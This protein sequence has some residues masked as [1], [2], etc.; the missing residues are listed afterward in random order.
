V[1]EAVVSGLASDEEKLKALHDWAA[2]RVAYD[3]AFLEGHYVPQ[4]AE[5][6]FARRTAVCAGYAQLY[7]SLARAVGLEAR[8]VVGQAKGAGGEVDG[9]GHAWNVVRAGGRER[10]VD[11]T[12][13]S[14]VLE[15]TPQGRVF[16]KR[17]RTDYLFAPPEV[18]GVDHFPNEPRD[19]LREAPLSRGDFMRQPQMAPE[20]F[21]RGLEL[22]A[23]TRS[24]V[25]VRGGVD[26][27]VDTSR[28][29]GATFLLA[30]RSPKGGGASVPCRVQEGPVSTVRCDFD[31]GGD[32]RV[33]LFASS[34]RYGVYDFVGEIEALDTR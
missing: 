4:D 27:V 5:A 25:S 19:Q 20:F 10:L 8:Y 34:K 13:D 9:A 30:S 29:R 32:Y 23:P 17:Y 3:P 22:R 11:V 21:V 6:V 2:D 14:G 1:A 28:A 26:V 18:F 12:W 7:A 16:K 24:Q 31:G 15:Q 33:A